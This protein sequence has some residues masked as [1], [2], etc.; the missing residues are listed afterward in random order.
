MQKQVTFVLPRAKTGGRKQRTE[1]VAALPPFS[2]SSAPRGAATPKKGSVQP[3][4]S[5][6]DAAPRILVCSGDFLSTIRTK[7]Q[8]QEG[9]LVWGS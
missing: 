7:E 8:L 5:S 3:A 6:P 4:P 2:C 9:G 1:A